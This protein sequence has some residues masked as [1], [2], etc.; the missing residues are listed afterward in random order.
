LA[1]EGNFGTHL[2]VSDLERA[3]VGLVQ[4]DGRC[5]PNIRHMGHLAQQT[6]AATD[7]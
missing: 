1:K 3:I 5:P 4:F 2:T 6:S 7:L